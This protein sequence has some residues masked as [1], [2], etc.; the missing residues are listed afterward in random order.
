MLKIHPKTVIDI[1]TGA[2]LEDH[3]I[4]Y[5]G[6]VELACGGDALA[7]QKQT[8]ANQQIAN[9]T[10]LTKIATSNN[11]AVQPFETNL[12][13]NGLPYM[14][15]LTNYNNGIL[16]QQ[17][18]PQKAALNR[19]LAGEGSTLPSGFATQARSD[20]DSTEANA[21]DAN[22]VSALQQNEAARQGAAAQ[23]NPLGYYT[24]ATGAGQSVTSAPPVQSSGI[25]NI[26]GGGLAG[27]L[28]NPNT[29]LS[30]TAWSL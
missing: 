5:D 25:G 16:S 15:Q 17:Y 10:A 19:Q 6:P 4:E 23:L 18:A 1:E 27:L 22:V 20:L 13:D 7:S 11:A 30:G 2:I 9:Q 3:W 14:S 24:G 29:T 8:A 21:F 28:A 26:L 12:L